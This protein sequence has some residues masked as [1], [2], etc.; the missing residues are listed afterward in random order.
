MIC[1]RLKNCLW[2]EPSVLPP[3]VRAPSTPSTLFL[4]YYCVMGKDEKEAG[5]GP[6]FWI[7]SHFWMVWSHSSKLNWD[8]SDSILYSV[9]FLHLVQQRIWLEMSP[10]L[11]YRWIWSKFENPHLSWKEALKVSCSVLL[12]DQPKEWM[13]MSPALNFLPIFRCSETIDPSWKE[14]PQIYW[15]AHLLLIQPWR[16]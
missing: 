10:V 13:M 11:N 15:S 16:C 3:R 6:I 7:T 5:I 1:F 2:A 14:S 4:I 9:T 12:F 8:T